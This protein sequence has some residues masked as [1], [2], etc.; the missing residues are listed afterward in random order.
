[1]RFIKELEKLFALMRSPAV[2]LPLERVALPSAVDIRVRAFY[3]AN[4]T[5]DSPTLD[6][7]LSYALT[8][9]SPTAPYT[10]SP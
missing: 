9:C 2:N 7:P 1:M 10:G 5:S 8:S 4:T 6:F 3:D